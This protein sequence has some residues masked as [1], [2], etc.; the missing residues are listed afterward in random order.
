MRKTTRRTER[1]NALKEKIATTENDGISRADFSAAATAEIPEK[2]EEIAVALKNV[3]FSYG[4]GD[5]PALKNVS[6]E[7]KKGEYVAILGHNGSGKST[8]ARLINGLLMPSS[9]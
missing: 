8:L 1:K 4:E 2:T 5:A 7:V 3:T 6:L 9:G